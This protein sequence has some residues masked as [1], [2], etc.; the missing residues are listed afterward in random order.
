MARL[1]GTAV[2]L[3]ASSDVTILT[4]GAGISAVRIDIANNDSIEHDYPI[5]Y[6]STRVGILKG[7]P[8]GEEGTWGPRHV[9]ASTAVKVT[10]PATTTTV[11]I[12]TATGEDD[13]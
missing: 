3:T 2:T 6:G 7:V 13:N 10:A 9:A 1:G 4:T 12:A 5:L 8:A 11:S